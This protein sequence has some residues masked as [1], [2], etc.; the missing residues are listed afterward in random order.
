VDL[1]ARYDRRVTGLTL[2]S[3]AVRV[4]EAFLA[5]RGTVADGRRFI[6]AALARRAAAVLQEAAEVRL[7]VRHGVPLIGIPG[8]DR[9]MGLIAERF[10]GHPSTDMWVAGVTGTNGKTTVTH[11]IAQAIAGDQSA[12]RALR[13]CGLIGTLGYGTFGALQ[14]GRHTTPDAVTLH[15]LLAD[16]RDRSVRHTVME[17]SSH[18][19][20]QGRVSG[21]AFD[22]AVFSNLSRDHLDYHG[23][24][25]AYAEAKR[26]LFRVPGLQAAV[27]NLDD[28]L[29]ASILADLAPGVEALGYSL[30][31]AHDARVRAT[32][33]EVDARGIRMEVTTPFGTGRLE[34]PLLGRF[35]AG[36]LLAALGALIMLGRPL[37]ALL[38]ALGGAQPVSGRMERFGGGEGEPLVVVDYAHTPDALEQVLATLRE[39]CRGTLTCVF[40]CGGERDRGK[41]P[42]MGAVAER[43]ADR[44]VVTDDNPRGED[45]NAIV[46]EIVSGMG[47]TADVRV[48]RDRERAIALALQD[49]GPGDVVLVAGKGHEDYQ[50]VAGQRRPYSD[51]AAVRALL[52]RRRRSAP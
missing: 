43:L 48:A 36:N 51:R 15:R 10:F 31:S 37:P 18:A 12:D 8:L 30:G 24:L 14:A 23:D 13:P 45:A 4:G 29:G 9:Q 17:V 50:E 7:E 40:G 22:V 5:I 21:V 47:P 11:L 27:V 44:A 35:N 25:A 33:L 32:T 26:G 42:E 16:L 2:D 52:A 3:R 38:S 39:H 1:P 28:P 34:S 20:S 46:R 6:D 41:R 19:L 49:S